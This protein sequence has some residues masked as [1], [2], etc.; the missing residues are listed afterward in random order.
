M[1]TGDWQRA[2]AAFRALDF[3]VAAELFMTPTAALCDYGLPA[4]S[5]LEKSNMARTAF[6]HRQQGKLHVQY[7]PAVV[8]PLAERR[9]DAWIIFELA[10]G[11]AWVNIF[12]MAISKRLMSMS[13]PPQ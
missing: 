5:F 1:S 10:N 9:A 6:A 11:W 2:R 3:A 4:E 7:R 12:G 13:L 8:E